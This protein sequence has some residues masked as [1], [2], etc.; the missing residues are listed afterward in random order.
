MTEATQNMTREQLS[1]EISDRLA[2]SLPLMDD[3]NRKIIEKSLDDRDKSSLHFPNV[4]ESLLAHFR[5]E[6]AKDPNL[7]AD[8][9]KMRKRFVDAISPDLHEK[10]FPLSEEL[11]TEVNDAATA[12]VS[13]FTHISRVANLKARFLGGGIDV[14]KATEKQVTGAVDHNEALLGILTLIN[15]TNHAKAQES[16]EP[17]K[18]E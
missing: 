15:G 6:V 18:A 11:V 10:S 9:E 17:R 16:D 2:D 1:K 7:Q 12:I 8:L 13:L 3:E 4:A 14:V 5:A